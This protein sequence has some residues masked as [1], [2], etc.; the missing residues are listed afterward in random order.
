[1][2]VPGP[3]SDLQHNSDQAA[4]MTTP[5]PKPLGSQGTPEISI[6]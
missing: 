4:A 3:G 6:F 5:D 1:M 2:E